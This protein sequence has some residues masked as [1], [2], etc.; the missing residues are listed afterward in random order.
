M[1][2][3]RKPTHGDFREA[4]RNGNLGVMDYYKMEN[5][6]TDTRMRS[7]ISKQDDNR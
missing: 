5:V 2:R 6:K 1:G 7:S 4:F 3:R